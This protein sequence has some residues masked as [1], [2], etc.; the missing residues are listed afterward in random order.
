MSKYSYNRT[1]TPP[2]PELVLDIF[3]PHTKQALKSVPGILDTGAD[4]TT[5]PS[6]FVETLR[7]IPSRKRLVED[8]EGKITEKVAYRVT[9]KIEKWIFEF[10]EAVD[11]NSE[12][13]L[14]GRNLLNQFKIVL[15]GKEGLSEISD[16]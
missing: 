10:I 8:F 5:I 13:I 2:I 12:E 11:I 1:Y 9:I 4:G 16:P 7:I 15:D 6:K 3:N 14:I